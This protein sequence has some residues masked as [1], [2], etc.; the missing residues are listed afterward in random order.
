MSMRI[1]FMGTP[2]FAETSLRAL[3]DGGFDVVGV[4]TQP[5]KPV[6][7]RQVLTPPP[8]KTLALQNNIPVWQPVKL[9]DGTAE[10]ILRELAPDVIAVVAYGRILPK[11]ILD[12]P[13]LGC[14]NIHGSLLPKY[15]GA[16][17]IQWAVINGE[18][19]TGVTAQFMA[20]ALDAGDIIGVKRTP[21]G[22]EETA[23]ELFDRLAPLGAQLLC[24][25]L[26]AMEKGS[27]PRVPQNEKEATFAPPLTRELAKIDFAKPGRLVVSHIRGMDP[28]P[29]ATAEIGGVNFKI[30]K[31]FHTEKPVAAPPGTVLNAGKDG[32]ELA[33]SDGSVTVT[34]LQA[35]GGRRMAAGEYLRGHPL[36]L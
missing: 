4:F 36:C 30:F 26:R 13:P 5:D 21:I 3:I 29:V 25:T 6:G 34:Q 16:A 33:V 32:I 15:R 27:V 20:E 8:V 1:V 11:A 17:P 23:G 7:R 9:R 14:V 28:W 31:A 12:L 22:P 18:A 2:D 10:N 19:E 35:P 24:E